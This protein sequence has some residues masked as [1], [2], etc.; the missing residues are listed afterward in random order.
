VPQ[1]QVGFC[2]S[3]VPQNQ[4]KEVSAG[5]VSRSDGLL[6]LEASRAKISQPGLKTDRGV[7]MGGARGIII[8][9]ASS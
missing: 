6:R 9:V 5:H 8:D 4:W 7:M 3:V 2:L 1:N